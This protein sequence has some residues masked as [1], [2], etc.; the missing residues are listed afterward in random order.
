L[1]AKGTNVSLKK[2]DWD[3][4]SKVDPVEIWVAVALALDLDPDDPQV[5]QARDGKLPPASC[6]HSDLVLLM[7]FQ[8]RLKEANLFPWNDIGPMREND[9]DPTA[10]RV[11]P[12]DFAGRVLRWGWN[13]PDRFSQ[14]H[15][16]R[17]D[18]DQWRD[19]PQAELY[20]VVA[21]SV[22]ISP[23][24]LTDDETFSL[25]LARKLRLPNEFL[26]RYRIAEAKLDQADDGMATV[27]GDHV[28]LGDFARFA[29][30]RSRNWSLPDAFPPAAASEQAP[31]GAKWPWGSYETEL[32]KHL[33]AA[34]EEFW[35]KY[36]P[37]K[38]LTAPTNAKIDEW[39]KARGLGSARVREIMAQIIRA[40]DAPRGPRSR[41]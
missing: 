30:A 36:E 23:D 6:G 5:A 38:P 26:K 9:G 18:W 7:R 20:K 32:L 19:I 11:D 16:K 3:R 4:W 8:R 29:K 2:P 1:G 10:I 33:A 22:D 14:P 34:V 40:D 24:F 41:S 37:G 21:A 28:R 13:L 12:V 31:A 39:L 25:K 15:S 35:I 17:V 27:D